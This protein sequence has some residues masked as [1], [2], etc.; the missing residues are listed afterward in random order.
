MSTQPSSPVLEGTVLDPPKAITIFGRDPAFWP[1]IIEGLLAVL[2]A[3]ALGVTN[4][5]AGLISAFISVLVG[6]YTAWATKDT[7][8]AWATGVAK[9]ALALFVYYGVHLTAEQISAV[10]L[11]APILI[12]AWQRTQT[13]PVAAPTDPSP[14]QVVPVSPPAGVDTDPET[15][16]ALAAGHVRYGDDPKVDAALHGDDGL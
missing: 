2:V 3:F 10:V 6:A 13:S 8:L 7:S 15:T 14:Q 5:S 1:G 11:F 16:A 9:A 4:E 12:G